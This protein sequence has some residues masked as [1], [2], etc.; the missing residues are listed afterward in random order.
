MPTIARASVDFPAP[1]GPMMPSDEPA[2]SEK[3]TPP[4]SARSEEGA[5]TERPATSSDD[6]GRGSFVFGSSAS[7]SPIWSR[8]RSQLCRAATKARQWPIACSTGDSAR[9]VMIETAMIMPG[10]ISFCSAR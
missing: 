6:F 1:L 10:V 7:G 8:S 3:L 5:A 4:S 9:A 2:L